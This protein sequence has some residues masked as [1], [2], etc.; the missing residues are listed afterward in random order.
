MQIKIPMVFIMRNTQIKTTMRSNS[1]EWL[2]SQKQTKASVEEEVGK[3]DP[4]YIGAV[5]GT[6]DTDKIGR[7]NK[8]KYLL[9]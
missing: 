8:A 4:S 9:S 3:L 2:Y 6:G 1:L 7:K 5:L